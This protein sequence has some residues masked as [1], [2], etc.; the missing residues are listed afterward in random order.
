MR[1]LVPY[2]GGRVRP[3]CG[4]GNPW[5]CRPTVHLY[6]SRP[7]MALSSA[8]RPRRLACRST[9]GRP[10][11]LVFELS[12]TALME[13]DGVVLVPTHSGTVW[14]LSGKEGTLLWRYKASNCMV[15]GILPL[16]GQEYVVSTMDGKLTCIHINE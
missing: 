15:N 5:D 11:G 16:G 14:A 6:M 10:W 3:G 8:C 1:P 4:S 2:A 9:G 7:W 12:P 13:H